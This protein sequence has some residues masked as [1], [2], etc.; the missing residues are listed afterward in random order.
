MA[1]HKRLL[2]LGTHDNARLQNAW[3]KYGEKSFVFSILECIDDRS[4]LIPREQY[5]IDTLM[6]SK[7]P[8]YNICPTAGSMLGFKF[9][10]SSRARVSAA[11]KGKPKPNGFGERVRAALLG[12]KHTPE[13]C[14]NMRAAL[15][16]KKHTEER[17]AARVAARRA[18]Y[19]GA[20]YPSMSH[21]HQ[22]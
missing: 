6:A 22:A 5:W 15:R 3:N 17:V 14:A 13:R 21:E 20:Y 16:G 4:Y 10:A 11:G 2:R 12:I 7:K 1:E 8:N 9:S 18:K 19:N